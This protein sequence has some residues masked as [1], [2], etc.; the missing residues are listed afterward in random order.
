MLFEMQQLAIFDQAE[1]ISIGKSRFGRE[2]LAFRLGNGKK[3]LM[4][5]GTHHGREYISAAFIMR[6][7]EDLVFDRAKPFVNREM[8]SEFSCIQSPISCNN[9]TISF[10]NSPFALGPTF[11]KRFPFFETQSTS[12]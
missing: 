12:I 6:S 8:L 7:V 5:V 10:G 2:I 4:I 1:I 9:L 11:N 3:K